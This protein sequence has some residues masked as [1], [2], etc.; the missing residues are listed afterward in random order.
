MPTI[1]CKDCGE[2]SHYRNTRGARIK[3]LVCE[4]GGKFGAAV[5]DRESDKWVPKPPPKKRA[6]S[7]NEVRFSKVVI[8]EFFLYRMS[9]YEKTSKNGAKNIGWPDSRPRKIGGSAIVKPIPE[10]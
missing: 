10:Q 9:K 6:L 8:G 5:Y 4:C 3:D 7:E 2:T 1:I